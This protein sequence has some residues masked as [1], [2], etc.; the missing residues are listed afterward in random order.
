MSTPNYP[1]DLR[2][3]GSTRWQ[4]GSWDIAAYANYFDNYFDKSKAPAT[5]IASWT[6]FDLHAAYAFPTTGN[7][8]FDGT[9]AALGVINLFDRYPPF[10]NNP[11]G[12][13]YDQENGDLTGRIVSL[14][15]RKKW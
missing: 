3:R 8:L 15:L 5:E 10:F 9:T 6:T 13:G 1:I 11:V 4:R 7:G 2:L 12:I 14:S